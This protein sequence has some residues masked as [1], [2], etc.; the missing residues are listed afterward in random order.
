MIHQSTII[1]RSFLHVET[2]YVKYEKEGKTT[3]EC[4]DK[5][6]PEKEYETA[7]GA[8]AACNANPECVF[9]ERDDCKNEFELCTST[10][11]KASFDDCIFKKGIF[12]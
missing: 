8:I 10:R 9:I 1:V 6:T 2:G 7:K 12:K 5:V 4:V 11:T 3:W